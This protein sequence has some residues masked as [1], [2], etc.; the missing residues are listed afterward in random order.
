[1]YRFSFVAIS[2]LLSA[3]AGTYARPDKTAGAKPKPPAAIGA[4]DYVRPCADAPATPKDAFECDRRSILAMTGE[5]HVRFMFDE[6]LPLKPGY[7][8]HEPQRSGGTELVFVV[9]DRGDFIALQHVLVMGKEHT[10]VK[11]WR[12][13]W[14]YEP[15]EVLK[16]RGNE[17][18]GYAPVD[19]AAA[20]HAWSQAVYEVDDAPRYAGVGSWVHADGVDAWTSDFTWRPL[21][22]REFTKRSDYQVL[23]AINRHTLSAGGWMHEQDNVKLL[24]K[25]DGTT[26]ALVREV[27]VNTYARTKDYDFGAGREYWSKTQ[28]FWKDARAAWHDTMTA[29]RDF[30]LQT[31]L[32]DKPRFEALFALADRATKGETIARSEIDQVL[33]RAVIGKSGV[34]KTP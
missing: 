27:G 3:C 5:Y 31:K 22:R 11:H 17:Q 29:R 33:D 20:K 28:T 18:F 34:A 30:T 16:F 9:E 14:Q 19:A 7:T 12:Q 1:M 25:P 10:V 8:Q 26:E 6:T 21:P 2:V 4:A 24:L 23:G 13:D 15:K 32:D